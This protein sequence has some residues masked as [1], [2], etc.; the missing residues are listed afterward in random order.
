MTQSSDSQWTYNP[1][2]NRRFSVTAWLAASLLFL[3][4]CLY[5]VSQ[6]PVIR[7]GDGMEYYALFFAWTET[8]RPWMNEVSFSAYR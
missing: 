4:I 7:I 8:L 1:T 6:L 5:A 2:S 3:S